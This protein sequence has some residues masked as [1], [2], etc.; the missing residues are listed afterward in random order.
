MRYEHKGIEVQIG[1]YSLHMHKAF[2]PFCSGKDYPGSRKAFDQCLTLP[3]YDELT[4]D[5]QAI[6]VEKIKSLLQ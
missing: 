3:L 5:Q 6:V 1:T 2:Y 4:S